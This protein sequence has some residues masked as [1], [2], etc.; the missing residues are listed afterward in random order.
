MCRNVHPLFFRH[1]LTW[2]YCIFTLFIYVESV[3]K[4][5]NVY[6]DIIALLSF[7]LSLGAEP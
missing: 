1:V 5:K 4:I 2:L 6:F 3:P 7:I